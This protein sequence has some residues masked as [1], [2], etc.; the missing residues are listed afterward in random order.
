MVSLTCIVGFEINFPLRRLASGPHFCAGTQRCSDKTLQN[1]E[2]SYRAVN[3]PFGLDGLCFL[4]RARRGQT[5]GLGKSWIPLAMIPP[6]N[7]LF[8]PMAF[9]AIVGNCHWRYSFR[10]APLFRRVFARPTDKDN[11]GNDPAKNERSETNN[12]YEIRSD[13]SR[14][15]RG[16]RQVHSG[17]CGK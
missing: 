15:F 4:I 11:P 9:A 16:S 10:V 5:T 1:S 14:N 13:Q 17:N 7:T 8:L 2:D 12:K 3:Y 6:A